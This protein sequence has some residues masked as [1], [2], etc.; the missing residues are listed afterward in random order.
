MICLKM[1][2]TIGDF[3][4]VAEGIKHGDGDGA[5]VPEA[6][7]KIQDSR[8]RSDYLLVTIVPVIVPFIITII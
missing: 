8:C 2:G 1:N 7:F 4:T 3:L 5:L 6:R